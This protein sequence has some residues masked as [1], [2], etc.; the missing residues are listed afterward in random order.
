MAYEYKLSPIDITGAIKAVQDNAF[1]QEQLRLKYEESM[2]KAIDDQQKLYSGKVRKQDVAEFDGKFAAY[3]EAQK[4]YQSLNRRGGRG[5]DLTVAKVLSDEARADMMSYIGESTS[6]GQ[7]QIAIGK[8]FKDPTKVLN[9]SK[10]TEVYT[11]FGMSVGEL[12]QKYGDLSKIPTNFE[13]EKEDFSNDDLKDL[14]GVIKSINPVSAQSSLSRPI[15]V[16]DP[17]TGQQKLSK[18]SITLMGKSMTVDVPINLIKAGADPI[19]TLNAVITSSKIQKNDDYMKVL[20][21]DLY[22]SA[23]DPSNPQVQKEAQDA[24][25]R[26]MEIYGITDKANVTPYHLFASNYVDQ[27]RMGDVEIEDWNKLGDIAGMFQKANGIKL[28]DAQLLKLKKEIN[29][30]KSGDG[31]KT[32]NQLLTIFTKAAATGLTNVDE[33]ATQFETLFKQQGYPMT[34]ETIL[35]AGEGTF[36]Q[37]QQL[38]NLLFPGV[39]KPANQR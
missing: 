34:K 33:W 14:S 31:M 30:V 17:N 26:T 18:K 28:K 21:R 10:Y 4:R 27:A 11:D 9:T 5:S 3:A 2:N 37:K 13:Y 25:K 8:M 38:I 15:P 36:Q 23:E 22:K 7:T 24:I 16:I 6:L 32:L 19:T 39:P 1:R 35:K 12:K 20:K 29:E